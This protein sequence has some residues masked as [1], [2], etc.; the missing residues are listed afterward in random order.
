MFLRLLVLADIHGDYVSLDKL[1]DS[2]K[3]Q[4]FDA[5][6]CPGDF[7]DMYSMPKEFSQTDIA[8]M[9]LQK[10]MTLNVP[11][12]CVPGNQDPYEILEFFDEY[13]INL[14]AKTKTV[15][16]TQFIGWGGALTPFN[17]LF[18]PSDEETKEALDSLLKKTKKGNFVLVT[19]DPPKDTNIDK[20]TGGNH[21]GS[22]VIRSFIEKAQPVLA[23]SAHIHES[24]GSDKLGETALFYPGAVFEGLYGIIEINGKQIKFESKKFEK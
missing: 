2:I 21:V 1:I 12:L 11:L 18:E 6:I 13:N 4:K 15:G 17:T 16:G 14:H 9:V 8:N 22:P 19:H 5:A 3:G 24:S 7:T 20:T 10:L 23:I